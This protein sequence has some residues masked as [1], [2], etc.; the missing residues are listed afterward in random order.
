MSKTLDERLKALSDV[1]TE[2][3]DIQQ[4][5]NLLRKVGVDTRNLSDDSVR[6]AMQDKPAQVAQ[7]IALAY[8]L[9][10]SPQDRRRPGEPDTKPWVPQNRTAEG[11]PVWAP[12]VKDWSIKREDYSDPNFVRKHLW[13]LSGEPERGA[14]TLWA[15]NGAKFDYNLT[16][17][18]KSEFHKEMAKAIIKLA[19]GAKAVFMAGTVGKM[20]LIYVDGRILNHPILFTHKST[21][22]N[23]ANDWEFVGSLPRKLSDIVRKFEAQADPQDADFKAWFNVQT[24]KMQPFDA[25]KTYY[26]ALRDDAKMFNIF[27]MSSMVKARIRAER[28]GWCAVGVN[29]GSGKVGAVVAAMTPEQALKAARMLFKARWKDGDWNSLTVKTNDETKTFSSRLEIRDY[30]KSSR[31]VFI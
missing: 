19:P 24:G 2:D 21:N 8:K 3:M 15:F 23:P 7:Q 17:L 1:L 13:E 12:G 26:D 5:G 30:L 29:S 25:T 11:Q 6:N 14:I 9:F 20:A 28:E 27:G 31:D 16:V 18:A 10:R 22:L 4:A